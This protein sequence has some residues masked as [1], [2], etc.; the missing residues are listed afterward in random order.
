MKKL[1]GALTSDIWV[2]FVKHDALYK[3]CLPTFKK[4][5]DK[6]ISTHG[7]FDS[8]NAF[9]P[10]K[11]PIEGGNAISH[12]GTAYMARQCMPIYL[13]SSTRIRSPHRLLFVVDTCVE[14]TV[15][16]YFFAKK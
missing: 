4:T 3:K 6:S 5:L 15:F 12:I 7:I 2:C 1:S 13:P 8:H 11:N 16:K 10:L 14:H 9:Y